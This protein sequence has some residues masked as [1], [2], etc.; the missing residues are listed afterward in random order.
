MSVTISGWVMKDMVGRLSSPKTKM[1]LQVKKQ[2]VRVKNFD[3]IIFRFFGLKL[4]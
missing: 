4:Q 3:E 2:A 1:T